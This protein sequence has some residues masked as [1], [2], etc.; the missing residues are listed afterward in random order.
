MKFKEVWVSNKFNSYL[1]QYWVDQVFQHTLNVFLKGH[2]EYNSH[3]SHL[4]ILPVL[5]E[6][7][8]SAMDHNP[9]N[10][11]K[12]HKLYWNNLKCITKIFENIYKVQLEAVGKV[13]TIAIEQFWR[14]NLFDNFKV[15]SFMDKLVLKPIV[16]INLCEIKVFMKFIQSA[17]TVNLIQNDLV[18]YFNDNPKALL[19]LLQ[20]MFTYVSFMVNEDGELLFSTDRKL[21]INKILRCT[22]ESSQC[23]VIQRK[24]IYLSQ[25]SKY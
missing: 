21:L 1:F 4:I 11:Q 18:Q 22:E 6:L 19:T 7:L 3:L 20:T 17:L 16:S 13:D 23:A 24:H 15:N 9:T 12:N 25:V 10:E 8:E 2:S 14:I 5:K